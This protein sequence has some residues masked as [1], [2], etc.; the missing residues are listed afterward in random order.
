MNIC[1]EFNWLQTEARVRI[2]QKYH[3]YEG[4]ILKIGI[5]KLSSR[6]ILKK[7]HSFYVYGPCIADLY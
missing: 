3:T 1:T 2:L 4:W 5:Q 7:K 6:H